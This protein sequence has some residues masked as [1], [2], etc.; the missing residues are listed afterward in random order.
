MRALV[1]L[2]IN[3]LTFML[4]VTADAWAEQSSPA[5]SRARPRAPF[6]FFSSGPPYEFWLTCLAMVWGVITLAVFMFASRRLEGSDVEEVCRPVIII[7][8]VVGAMIFS[9]GGYSQE[10][11]SAAFA[12]F[13]SIAGYIFGRISSGPD[14]AREE[15][16]R[17]TRLS[18][19][20]QRDH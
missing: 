10:Q 5:T 15:E 17:N 19:D 9:T 6:E 7:S 20:S 3:V 13:G 2:P 14:D 8:V 12:V 4:M 11:L 1:W 16:Q 18:S